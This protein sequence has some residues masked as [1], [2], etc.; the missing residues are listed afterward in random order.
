MYVLT[1][2]LTEMMTEL[3][4]DSRGF[5]MAR[6]VSVRL[7]ILKVEERQLWPEK[8][9]YGKCSKISNTFF[10]PFLFS[11]K[12]LVFRAGIHKMLVRLANREAV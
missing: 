12:I 4:S 8:F 2:I 10:L 6:F 1:C 5:K 9:W 7:Q 3:K 11:N